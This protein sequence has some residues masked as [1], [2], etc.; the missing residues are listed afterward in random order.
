MK[1]QRGRPS[2]PWP[3]PTPRRSPLAGWVRADGGAMPLVG[4]PL[5]RQRFAGKDAPAAAYLQMCS[6][7]SNAW[8]RR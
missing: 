8:R 1:S 7:I 4:Q 5:L 6:R 3:P 2:G